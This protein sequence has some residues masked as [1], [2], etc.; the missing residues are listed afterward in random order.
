[1]LG[2]KVSRDALLAL[3]SERDSRYRTRRTGGLTAEEARA[4]RDYRRA[5][6]ARLPEASRAVA[7]LELNRWYPPSP[8]AGGR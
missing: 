2:H 5:E 8:M 3:W 7:N 1:M 4:V 6:I